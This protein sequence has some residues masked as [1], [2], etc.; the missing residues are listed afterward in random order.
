LKGKNV[1]LLGNG[2]ASNLTTLGEIIVNL[3]LPKI[4]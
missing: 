1:I 4:S 2:V 3:L